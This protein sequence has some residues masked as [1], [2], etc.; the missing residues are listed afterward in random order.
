MTLPN[1]F[2]PG[3]RDGAVISPEDTTD[4]I[5][6]ARALYPHPGLG[7]G[8]YRRAVSGLTRRAKAEPQM[9]RVLVS[10]LEDLRGEATPTD[11][12]EE[13][14]RLLLSRR[15][16]TDFF[17]TVR[18]AVAWA[19][20]DDHEL[21]VHIGYPGESFVRGGYLHRGFDDLAWLPEPRTAE[22]DQPMAEV[23][24]TAGDVTPITAPEQEEVA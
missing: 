10:G 22:S 4:L 1:G 15:Q 21:W 19:L 9:L 6:I 3:L 17:H 8:P 18:S 11:A 24:S 14:L 23:V 16:D 7:D 5:A 13:R 2:R 20:Y 12:D